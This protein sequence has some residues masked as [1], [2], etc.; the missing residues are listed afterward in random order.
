MPGLSLHDL[1]L[2]TRTLRRRPGFTAVAVCALAVGFGAN[3]AIF[4]VVNSVLLQPLPYPGADRMV[5]ISGKSRLAFEGQV[6]TSPA[7]FVQW[8][9]SN[10]VFTELVACAGTNVTLTLSDRADEVRAVQ[11]SNDLLSMLQA[12]P[13]LGQMFS[14]RDFEAGG[15]TRILV[16]DRL[17]RTFFE[18]DP[19]IVGRPLL[20]NGQTAYVA[21][22]M[23]ADFQFPSRDTDLWQPLRFSSAQLGVRAR[24]FL[25]VYGRLKPD[26]T[27]EQASRDLLAIVHRMEQ[28][29]PDWMKGRGVEVTP[30]HEKLSANVKPTLL[31]LLGIVTLVLVIACANV[32]HLLL[33]RMAQRR[34]EIALRSALG[35]SPGQIMRQV[36]MECLVLAVT[37]AALGLLLAPLSLR[38]LAVLLQSE[39][40]TAATTTTVEAGLDWRILLYTFGIALA[41][42]FM[43]GLAPASSATRVNLT[44]AFQDGSPNSSDSSRTRSTRALLIIGEVAL[45]IV[46][47]AGAGL[48]IRSFVELQQ[49]RRGYDARSLLT[50][51]IPVPRRADLTPQD[52]AIFLTSL[53]DD[54]RGLPGVRSAAV[55]TGLPLGGLNASVTLNIEG[56]A[57]ESVEDMPWAN[58][59][60][61]SDTYFETMGTRVL[62]GRSFSASDTATSMRVAI[63]NQALVRQ[64]WPSTDPIGKRLGPSRDGLVVVGVVEDL[65]QESLQTEQS[66]T[67]YVPYTQ[68]DSLAATA[69][70]LVVRTVIDPA[71]LAEPVKRS[72]RR[73]DSGQV[74]RDV[75]TMEQVV[76]RSVG[77]QRALMLLMAIFGGIALLLACAGVYSANQYSVVQRTRELGIR[78]SLGARRT[79]IVALVVRQG[80]APVGI[81]IA[82]GLGVA[83]AA[84]RAM[85]TLLY[86]ISPLD[87][88]TFIVVAAIALGVALLALSLPAWRA[89][90]INPLVALR[91]E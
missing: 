44:D 86:G 88:M 48:L 27:P 39:G 18:A 15:T 21:G 58:I 30:L 36:F 2:A 23:P 51:R 70:F 75:R 10:R 60:T 1:K 71:Q 82:L 57:P 90:A 67:M 16:S 63:V 80:M 54:V 46:I 34:R 68:R 45:T 7:E 47:L 85:V 52:R 8:R 42:V 32:S 53:L 29:Y 9:E 14:A 17:W 65:R 91:H 19:N 12:Q 81:G 56:Y 66:P 69:N 83:M 62:R 35:G 77:Q 79:E 4:S 76:A 40:W 73:L 84:S 31:M 78:M 20:L 41:A 22:V 5:S 11:V 64:Y 24:R 3:T 61:I 50:M 87:P 37:A 55:V 6:L 33:A 43:F 26:V 38:T 72:I 59:N 25:D 13:Q 28:D 74:I 89:T 49:V